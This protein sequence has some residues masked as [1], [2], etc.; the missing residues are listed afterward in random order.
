MRRLH[1]HNSKARM[2]RRGVIVP[3]VAI[4]ILVVGGGIALVLDRLWLAS[5]RTELLTIAEGASLAACRNLIDEH[6]LKFPNHRLDD[7][8]GQSRRLAI[9][10]QAAA[11]IA[12]SN[13]V[14]GESVKLDVSDTGDVRF[15]KLARQS[16]TNKILFLETDR[17]PTSVVVSAY[18]TRSR[19]NPVALLFQELTGQLAGDVAARA[20]ATWSNRIVGLRPHANLPTPVLPIV[21]LEH[22]PTGKQLETWSRQIEEFHGLDRYRFDA[23]TGFVANG[24]DGLPEIVLEWSTTRPADVVPN[25]GLVEMGSFGE[26]NI[27]LRQLKNG[28][29]HDDLRGRDGEIRLLPNKVELW[30][31]EQLTQAECQ[32]LRELIGQCRI[33]CLCGPPQSSIESH[34]RLRFPLTRFVAARVMAIHV[35]PQQS[36]QIVLQPAVVVT[37]TAILAALPGDQF[38]GSVPPNP[39][40]YKIQVTQ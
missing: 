6:H 28:W 24:S 19:N 30:G 40:I 11:D 7:D 34:R 9:A 35:V 39:Y 38:D 17:E 8:D 16:D 13:T 23:D 2:T 15:G 29:R 18:R 32:T 14:V 12:A 25:H 1:P 10:K 27:T 20:E 21:V 31:R 22:D 33:V 3:L 4:A 36:I 37:R 5:A 26:H